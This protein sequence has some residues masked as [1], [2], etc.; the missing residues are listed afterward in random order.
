VVT[1]D[2]TVVDVDIISIALHSIGQLLGLGNSN[3][4]TAV[5]YTSYS[6]GSLKR[7]LACDDRNAVVFRYPSGEDVGF[8]PAVPEQN[9][10]RSP[11]AFQAAGKA[12]TSSYGTASF[13]FPLPRSTPC[14]RCSARMQRIAFVTEASAIRKILDAVGY[15]GDSP[16]AAA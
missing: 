2:D 7:D 4:T 10:S 16:A 9:P 11:Q 3:D 5:M 6:A 1:V 15:P 14:P 8:C 12:A 13:D